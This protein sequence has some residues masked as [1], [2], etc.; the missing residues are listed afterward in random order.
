MNILQQYIHLS[1]YARFRED[2]GRRENLNET[3]DR[4]INFFK[5]RLSLP[6]QV[7]EELRKGIID[8]EVMPS[9]RALMSAGPALERENLCGYNCAYLAIDSVELV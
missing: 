4:Y 1:R 5:N 7:W 6:T 8:L 2:D 3:A 9:M